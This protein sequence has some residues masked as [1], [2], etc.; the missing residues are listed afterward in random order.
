MEN[1]T[2]KLG[3]SAEDIRA[4][5]ASKTCR[6]FEKDIKETHDYADEMR[7]IAAR[8][9]HKFRV[10]RGHTGSQINFQL[11]LCCRLQNMTPEQ[12]VDHFEKDFMPNEPGAV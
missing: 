4:A 12:A 2:T 9:G 7:L 5:V 11:G 8:R 10:G 3:A 1:T 6:A